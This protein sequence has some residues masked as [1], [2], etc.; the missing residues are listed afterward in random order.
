MNIL[1]V[2]SGA[3]E[4]A[5]VW[6]LKDSPRVDGIFVVP[7][8][9]GTGFV[10]TNLPGS[11]GDLEQLARLAMDHEIDLTIVGPEVPLAEGIVDMFRDRGLAVFGPTKSAARIEAS[12]AFAKELMSRHDIPCPDFKVCRS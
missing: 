9:A 2:G 12:K 3:R 4:H 7:G 8:N 6:R 1:V 5:I 11:A 10:A